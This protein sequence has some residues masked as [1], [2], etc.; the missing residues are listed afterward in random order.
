MMCLNSWVLYSTQ[1][2]NS[3]AMMSILEMVS[4]AL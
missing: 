2:K 1:F 3:N 4:F